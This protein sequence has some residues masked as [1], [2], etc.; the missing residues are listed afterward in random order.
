MAKVTHIGN[1]PYTQCMMCGTTGSYEFHHIIPKRLRV[2]TGSVITHLY[3]LL[4][5]K[6]QTKHTLKIVPENLCIKVCRACHKKL[7]PENVYV[8]KEETHDS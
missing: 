2:K 1:E 3:G 4:N 6:E 5:E 7:H 8:C